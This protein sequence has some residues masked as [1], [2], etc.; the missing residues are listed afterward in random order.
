[1]VIHRVVS[2][3]C[4]SYRTRTAAPEPRRSGALGTGE[5]PCKTRGASARSG[6][7]PIGLGEKIVADKWRRLAQMGWIVLGTD[8]LPLRDARGVGNEREG[9]PIGF[10]SRIRRRPSQP[11][12]MRA[13]RG[14]RGSRVNLGRPR[15][16]MVEERPPAAKGR[17]M[18]S[19]P[20]RDNWQR[21]GRGRLGGAPLRQRMSPREWK[22][23]AEGP[24]PAGGRTE[25]AD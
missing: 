9:G 11:P 12:R 13:G 7:E 6:R 21:L 14:I 23:T 8:G 19:D 17:R 5:R 4:G 1:M 24:H 18:A 22:G 15:R 25:S 2:L 20:P 3:Q 10:G 16:W